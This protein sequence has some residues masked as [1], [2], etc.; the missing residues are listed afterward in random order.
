MMPVPP[1]NGAPS[2]GL[3]KRFENGNPVSFF[4][5]KLER[6]GSGDG[7][8]SCGAESDPYC[9]RSKQGRKALLAADH[10]SSGAEFTERSAGENVVNQGF[11]G[12]PH[13]LSRQK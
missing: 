2:T 11:H 10:A 7:T 13:V 4:S 12:I 5:H 3:S 6:T 8:P 9:S 1:R